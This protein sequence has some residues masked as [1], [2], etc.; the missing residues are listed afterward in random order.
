MGLLSGDVLQRSHRRTGHRAD[1]IEHPAVALLQKRLSRR[2]AHEDSQFLSVG[3]HEQP[4][5]FAEAG[6]TGAVHLPHDRGEEGPGIVAPTTVAITLIDDQ[7]ACE[8]IDV[9]RILDLAEQ[10]PL[11]RRRIER[12]ENAIAASSVVESVRVTVVRIGNDGSVS[13]L[14]RTAQYFAYRCALTCSGRAYE[15]EVFGFILQR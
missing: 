14:E 2:A 12:I 4:V 5:Q 1:G 9:V 13:P 11:H 7:R 10:V 15:L 6:V 8:L 3:L